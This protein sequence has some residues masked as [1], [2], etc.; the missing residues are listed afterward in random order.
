MQTDCLSFFSFNSDGTIEANKQKSLEEQQK[1]LETIEI[2]GL[3][4]KSLN[5]E[6]EMRL[7]MFQSLTEDEFKTA[8]SNI[9]QRGPNGE[10]ESFYFVPLSY[11]GI[12]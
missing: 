7:K 8:I 2:L 12:I 4:D 10:F 11:Y 6:R 9:G 3:D 5:L 1:A